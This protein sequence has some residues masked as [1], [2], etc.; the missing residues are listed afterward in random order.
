MYETDNKIPKS[1][2]I[3]RIYNPAGVWYNIDTT[4]GEHPEERKGKGK[5]KTIK[6]LLDYLRETANITICNTHGSILYEGQLGEMPISVVRGTIVNRIEGLG[7]LNDII[8]EVS[9]A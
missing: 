2:S 4:K 1:L 5:M 8:I 9:Q 6:F 7:G 3:L